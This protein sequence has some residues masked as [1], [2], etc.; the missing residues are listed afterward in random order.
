MPFLGMQS[1]R[2]SQT[3]VFAQL[4]QK[5]QESFKNTDA[6]ALIQAYRHRGRE[7]V[8]FMTPL[9]IWVP[10]Q[11]WEPQ[12][13]I[14]VPSFIWSTTLFQCRV[15]VG[16]TQGSIFLNVFVTQK[17]QLQFHVDWIDRLGLALEI[18]WT[19]GEEKSSTFRFLWPLSCYW[20]VGVTEGPASVNAHR[21]T[22]A[23][24]TRLLTHPGQLKHSTRAACLIPLLRED[25]ANQPWHSSLLNLER[26]WNPSNQSW[27]KEWNLFTLLVIPTNNTLV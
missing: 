25:T 24:A 3:S 6:Q 20:A 14:H 10:S 2:V 17:K 23:W 15:G 1:I 18:S 13:R 11:L 22:G 8:F 7:S 19:P 5:H 27:H 4:Y 9:V 16:C 21:V 26:P 12:S